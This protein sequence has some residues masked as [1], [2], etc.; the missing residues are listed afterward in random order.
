M[1]EARGI[2]NYV[3]LPIREN[4]QKYFHYLHPE[5]LNAKLIT[6]RLEIEYLI[7]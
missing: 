4:I 2:Q 7:L 6:G 1:N 5:I 3:S